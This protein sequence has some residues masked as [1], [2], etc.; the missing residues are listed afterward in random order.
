MEETY[1]AWHSKGPGQQLEPCTLTAGPLKELDVEIAVEACAICHSDLHLI[2]DDWGI[3]RFPLVPGH[4][5]V[6]RVARVGRGVKAVAPGQQVGVG[7]QRGCCG[8]CG[9]CKSGREHLCQGGKR[10][11]CVDQAGGF[12]ER[13]RTDERFTFP[14]PAGMAAADAAPLLCAGVTVFA[15]LRRWLTKPGMRVGIVGLGGLG[16]LA[17]PFARALGGRVT[18]FDP[19]A[20]KADEA[21][22]LGA[23]QLVVA[24]EPA[25]V[26]AAGGFDLILTAAPADLEW[27]LWLEALALGGV[28][29]L[30]GVPPRPLAINA[31]HLL[32]G[33]KIVTGSVIGSPEDMRATLA[34]AAKHGIRPMVDVLPMSAINEGVR[35]VRAGEARYRVVLMAAPSID[36]WTF[37]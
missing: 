13:V 35:R 31:D 33:Q 37:R 17:V 12:A 28:L 4:E 18:A 24:T 8:A 6:G 30:V 34:F 23:E 20:A 2:D 26:R 29:C 3:T 27:N 16:H 9:P 25:A 1:Q 14:I 5:V 32:D 7:W 22:H 15:P 36:P 19:V 21:R 11:T 10:R